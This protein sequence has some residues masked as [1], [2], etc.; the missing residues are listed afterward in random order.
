[1]IQT[2]QSVWLRGFIL[3]L[4]WLVAATVISPTTAPSRS[5]EGPADAPQ[6]DLRVAL[7]LPQ[8]IIEEKHPGTELTPKQKRELMKSN[9]A[10]MKNDAAQLASI[11]NELRDE[12]NKTSVDILSMD[13]IHRAE[14]IEKLARKIK[15][16]AKGY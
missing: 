7:L 13:V 1:M 8:R 5:A 9:F 10:K 15:E 12:L 11:A 4:G 16:E 3:P 2:H 6:A 14:K